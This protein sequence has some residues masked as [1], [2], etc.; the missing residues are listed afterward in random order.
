MSSFLN[1]HGLSDLYISS[2]TLSPVKWSNSELSI[3]SVTLSSVSGTISK[4][5]NLTLNLANLKTLRGSS[6]NA[7]DTCLNF[8]FQ[9]P[10]VH[11]MGLLE[12]HVH[13]PLSH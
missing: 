4:S 9:C 6:E 1:N 2:Q 5:S 7:S 13:P 10:F 8:L 12:F 3:I 11:Q